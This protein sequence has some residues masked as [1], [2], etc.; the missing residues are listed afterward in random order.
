MVTADTASVADLSSDPHPILQRLRAEGPISWIPSLDGWLV[1]SH[2]HAVDVLLDTETFTVDDP[3][4]STRQ[5]IGPSM[6][7]LDGLEHRRHRDPFAGPF[8][9]AR[10]RELQ[11]FA[12]ETASSL[13]AG[14][15]GRGFAD[16]RSE[17]AGPLAVQVMARVLDLHDVEVDEVLAWYEEIVDAVHSVTEGGEV[18]ESGHAA[19]A[20]LAA[21]VERDRSASAL[22]AP[23]E[24]EGTLTVDEIA[25]N[26]AV[27]LFGGI[28]TSESS[29]A[30]AFRYLLDDL[31][32]MEALRDDR[33]LVRPFVEETFRLEPSAAAVDRYATRDAV[34]G[35][36]EITAGEL[37]RVSLSGANR[38]PSVFANPDRFD[39]GRDFGRS[40]TFARG[41]HAC[42]GIHLARLEAVA[43]V[44]ALIEHPGVAADDLEPI[45][46]LVFRAPETVA[47]IWPDG[48][49]RVE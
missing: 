19:F 24:E 15:V 34:L 49:G 43:A 41:P 29:S 12:R 10:I 47:A 2:Q 16:L 45:T 30:I 22:L 42:L 7:S 18:P 3:R 20:A 17:V 44:T 33:S 39:I 48:I 1:T 21:A 26:V 8:R 46:G 4:F 31:G 5:V 25:S 23:V 14:A 35:G 11:D 27:L 40:V 28:V 13:I 9:A 36:S 6:L 38:D 32:L 37:V